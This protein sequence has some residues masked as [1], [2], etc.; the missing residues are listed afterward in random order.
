[1]ADKFSDGIKQ[2]LARMYDLGALQSSLVDFYKIPGRNL[3]T[4]TE[5]YFNWQNTRRKFHCWPYTNTIHGIPSP[6]LE[7]SNDSGEKKLGLNFASQD[8]LSLSSHPKVR[9]AAKYAVDEYGLHSAGSPCLQGNTSLSVKLEKEL[10]ESLKMREVVLYSTGWA[11]GFGAITGL[12]RSN[13]HIIMDKFIHNCLGTGANA[14]TKNVHRVSHLSNNS[15]EKKLK[16][17][18]EKDSDNAIL[19]ITEGL[20]SMDADTPDIVLL[21]DICHQYDATLLVD[22]AHDFGSMG[23]DGTGFIG[24]QNMLGKVDLVMGSFSKTFA[25]NGG[26]VATN[27]SAVKQYLKYYGSPHLFSNALSPVQCAVVSEALRIVQ[28]EEGEYLRQKMIDVSKSLRCGLTSGGI[29]VIGNPSPIVPAMLG[30]EAVARLTAALCFNRG[31]FA[32]PVEF[33]GVDVGKARFRIQVMSNHSKEDAAKAV[34]IITQSYAEAKQIVE[35][36][37]VRP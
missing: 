3:L 1:M 27:S 21:Q 25:S 14:A 34:S 12:V 30:S 15:F 11:A 5:P 16:E 23:P 6:K 33:P 8:Y 32:N 4:R 19:V 7:V 10:A 35:S 2:E 31:L 24:T 29:E 18:R 20:F 26:F 28:S 36:S 22:V 37:C 9:E 13:D 17:I